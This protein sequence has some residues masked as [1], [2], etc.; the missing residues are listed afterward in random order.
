M[1][2]A[3]LNDIYF[4]AFVLL[5]HTLHNV[6]EKKRAPFRFIVCGVCAKG[7]LD[8]VRLVIEKYATF[9]GSIDYYGKQLSVFF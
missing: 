3:G 7:F 4:F 5:F 9:H 8:I 6:G 2:S 1:V